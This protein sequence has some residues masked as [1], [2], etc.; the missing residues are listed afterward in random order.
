MNNHDRREHPRIFH[1]LPTTIH[2]NDNL[3]GDGGTVDVSR[4]GALLDS[5]VP[6]GAGHDVV[7]DFQTRF[8]SLDGVKARVKRSFPAFWGHR[9]LLAVEFR[10]LSDELIQVIEFESAS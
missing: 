1:R 6:L 9:H 5:P 8:A 3:L 10:N 2:F 4:G 7:L